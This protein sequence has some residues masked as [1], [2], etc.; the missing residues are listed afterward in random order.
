MLR[1]QPPASPH[2][3]LGH[4]HPIRTSTV[5]SRRVEPHGTVRDC[6]GIRRVHP[7]QLCCESR[8]NARRTD[9]ADSGSLVTPHF[10][11]SI[12]HLYERSRISPVAGQGGANNSTDPTFRDRSGSWQ[13][14]K[15][16]DST[17]AT[18]ASLPEQAQLFLHFQRRHVVRLV[19]L[20][21]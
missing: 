9:A 3:A 13:S 10:G 16:A 4:R 17:I 5:V 7:L 1:S 21:R 18:N 12:V 19:C 6:T 11:H 20:C 15:L 14:R 8:P 2:C